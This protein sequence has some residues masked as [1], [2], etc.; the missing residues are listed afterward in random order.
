MISHLQ[1]HVK[2]P[3]IL[4][5]EDPPPPSL[6]STV[7]PVPPSSAT[8]PPVFICGTANNN[9]D[10]AVSYLTTPASVTDPNPA[11]S[12]VSSIVHYMNN[13]NNNNRKRKSS[14]STASTSDTMS[15]H[16]FVDEGFKEKTML[17]LK[18]R[19]IEKD[20]IQPI[21]ALY[22]YKNYGI[23]GLQ[24]VGGGDSKSERF[25]ACSSCQN[26]YFRFKKCGPDICDPWQLDTPGK[27]ARTRVRST[28]SA[29]VKTP[30]VSFQCLNKIRIDEHFLN[31][32]AK[33]C[34]MSLDTTCRQK[35]LEFQT[36]AMDAS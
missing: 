4:S 24:S 3:P 30:M 28:N 12:S 32:N 25:Y 23:P 13:N 19:R 2:L 20:K 27:N 10:D 29:G 36:K 31:Q 33:V 5:Q 26:Y 18:G 1:H 34:C 9:N 8:V 21:A 22:A 35:S 17:E 15:G 6:S 14:T 11:T 16:I 7:P